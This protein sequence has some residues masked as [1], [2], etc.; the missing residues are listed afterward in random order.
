MV[1]SSGVAIELSGAYYADV[2]AL[3]STSTP[4]KSSFFVAT[5][6]RHYLEPK[7]QVYR[8]NLVGLTA[9]TTSMRPDVISLVAPV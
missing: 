9:L 4:T 8:I 2:D 7:N 6:T 1:L 5:P 3:N